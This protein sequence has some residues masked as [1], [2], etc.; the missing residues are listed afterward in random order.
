M[1][2]AFIACHQR[3]IVFLTGF[4]GSGGVEET[5]CAITKVV[6][7]DVVRVPNCMSSLESRFVMAQVPVVKGS[8]LM[9]KAVV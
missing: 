5:D 2:R 4:V 7:D 9:V 3:F 8:V 6:A 1:L